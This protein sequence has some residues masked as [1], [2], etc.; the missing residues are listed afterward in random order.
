VSIV[1]VGLS[2]AWPITFIGV[3]YLVGM[4]GITISIHLP[5]NKHIQGLKIEE[6]SRQSL[7]EERVKFEARWNFYN[8]I[9]TLVSL[10]VSLSLLML[11]NSR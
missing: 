3:I 6:L 8:D 11:L 10:L 5:L 4:Q 1:S 2:E 9:R 7:S